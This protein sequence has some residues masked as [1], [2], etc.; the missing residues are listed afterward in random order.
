MINGVLSKNPIDA[1]RRADSTLEGHGYDPPAH[2]P[3][4]H[5]EP[6]SGATPV[7]GVPAATSGIR[8][9][10]APSPTCARSAA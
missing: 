6:P 2:R 4:G 9:R 5:R 7:F 8:S 1:V 10:G 3:D